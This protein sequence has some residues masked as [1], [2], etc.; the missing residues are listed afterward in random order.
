MEEA[1]LGSEEQDEDEEEEAE[2][3]GEPGGEGGEG[4]VTEEA[5]LLTQVGGPP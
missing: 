4:G 3:D 1:E 2:E 5:I